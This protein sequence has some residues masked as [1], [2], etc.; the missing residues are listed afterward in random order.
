[1]VI[2]PNR[3]VIATVKHTVWRLEAI[4]F[5]APPSAANVKGRRRSTASV[6]GSR[7]HPHTMSPTAAIVGTQN[8]TRHGAIAFNAA[9]RPGARI[10]TR[11]NTA[12]IIDISR[13]MPSPS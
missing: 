6:S 10:G 8:T 1:M 3:N 2:T 7:R 11:R 13:A 9:P 5:T 12:M 4:T